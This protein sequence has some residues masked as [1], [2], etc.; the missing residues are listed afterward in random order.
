MSSLAI[1]VISNRDHV[2]DFTRCLA[3]MVAHIASRPTFGNVDLKIAKN[4]SLLSVARQE[5]LDECMS[6]KHSHM[7]MLDDDMVFPPDLAH[8]L[9]SKGKRCIGVNSL[10]KNPDYLHYTAK[11]LDGQWVESKGKEG[12][13]QVAAVGLAL[14]MLDLDVMRKIPKPHFEVRW[15]EEKQIY[16]GEDMYFC[17]KLNEAGEKVFID[18]DLS[19]RCGHVGSLVYTF[20]FYDRFKE[21]CQKPQQS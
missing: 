10:R 6:E 13:Q 21:T 4:C 3:H 15:N 5:M 2:P 19:N 11:G 12:I 20:G 16:A 1:C 7:L 8:Q 14:F 18:H 9:Y 17:R